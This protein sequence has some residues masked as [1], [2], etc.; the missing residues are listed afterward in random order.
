MKDQPSSSLKG[1]VIDTT[2]DGEIDCYN[3]K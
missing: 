1:D 2:I 3:H